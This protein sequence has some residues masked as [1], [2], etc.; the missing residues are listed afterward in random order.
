MVR[1]QDNLEPDS[2]PDCAPIALPST[3]QPIT[4]PPENEE[5][6]TPFAETTPPDADRPVAEADTDEDLASTI[7]A[8]SVRIASQRLARQNVGS[9][10]LQVLLVILLVGASS[11]FLLY[12]ITTQIPKIHGNAAATA[13]V[14]MMATANPH[15]GPYGGTLALFDSMTGPGSIFG[16]ETKEDRESSCNF[17]GRAYYVA[18]PCF[19]WG[20]ENTFT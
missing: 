5:Q 9:K 3:S 14:Q 20:I 17:S 10:V 19:A 11:G 4:L 7:L 8:Q 6:R 15:P 2:L 16:W 18:G 13:T 12:E 1:E